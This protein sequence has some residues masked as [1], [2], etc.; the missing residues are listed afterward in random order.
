MSKTEQNVVIEFN[1]VLKETYF[2]LFHQNTITSIAPSSYPQTTSINSQQSKDVGF[3]QLFLNIPMIQDLKQVF[4]QDLSAFK[5]QK[6][7]DFESFIDTILLVSLQT[8]QECNRAKQ[9][10]LKSLKQR[11]REVYLMQ[12]ENLFRGLT[13][14]EQI[15]FFVL[16]SR[17]NSFNECLS[18]FRDYMDLLPPEALKTLTS[19]HE[20][21]LIDDKIPSLDFFIEHMN[22]FYKQMF[23]TLHSFVWFMRHT[24]IKMKRCLLEYAVASILEDVE[25]LPNKDRDLFMAS[26]QQLLEKSLMDTELINFKVYDIDLLIEKQRE[27]VRNLHQRD[28]IWFQHF[29]D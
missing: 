22:Q 2:T 20:E 23:D 16:K 5:F 3:P 25:R 9:F 29:R 15:A 6:V 17:E 10:A 27:M 1:R 13:K 4:E 11:V 18:P 8:L 14:E 26:H 19:L 21:L 28:L 12:V 24:M 7:Q